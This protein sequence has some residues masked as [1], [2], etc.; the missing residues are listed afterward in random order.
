MNEDY[1]CEKMKKIFKSLPMNWFHKPWERSRKGIPD[2][3][4]CNHGRFVA[5][6]VKKAKDLA[7]LKAKLL[8]H[9]F[10]TLQIANLRRIQKA[11]G[12]AFG[13]VYF[14]DKFYRVDWKDIR[15]DGNL[16]GSDLTTYIEDWEKFFNTREI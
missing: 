1:V 3:L 11:G 7:S 9:P 10:T 6:E 16:Y 12:L 4:L 8:D 5:L 14:R 15:P 2:F 13:I